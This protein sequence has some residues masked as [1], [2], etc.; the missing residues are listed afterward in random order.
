M[1]VKSVLVFTV[2][3]ALLASCQ[4]ATPAPTVAVA[5]TAPTAVAAPSNTPR[6]IVTS[7]PIPNGP[8]LLRSD[9]SLRK[10]VDRNGGDI[11]LALNPKDGAVFL[12]NPG[13]GVYRVTLTDPGSVDLVAATGEIFT[14]GVTPSGM[15]FGPDGTLYVVGNVVTKQTSNVAI[16]RKGVADAAGKYTWSFLA[17]TEPYPLSGTNFDHL[18]NGIAV[19]PDGKYVYVNAGSRSDHGEVETN[20]GAWPDTREVPLTS[21]IMRIPADSTNLILPNDEAKLKSMGY[22]F[23]DGT[24]NSYDPAFAP[25]G[26]LFAGENGPDADYP[27]EINW[28]REGLHYGFPWRFGNQDLPQATSP[29]Y[30]PT[31]D[32]H[33]HNDFVAVTSGTYKSDPTFPKAPMA[34]TDPIA[35]AGPDGVQFRAD[36]GTAHDVGTEG[37][38]TYSFT[39]HRSPL[40]LVF[41]SDNA[42]M[43]A[44]L[45]GSDNKLSGFIVS[46]GAAG[47]T[48][49]DKGLDL[50]HIVL[51]KSS[52][53]YTMTSE[54]V[55][56]EFK[57]PIDTVLIGN[58]LYVLEFGD[59]AA[60]WELTFNK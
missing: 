41:V 56:R 24:R 36:D 34:F 33:L 29:N 49:T 39:P 15:V 37:G 2:A 40:G 28:L 16:I 14:N 48:L 50:L 20:K 57:N 9:I 25:N 43:P 31:T 47:G 13:E 21:A 59:G 60:I 32:K 5:T 45:Q 58:K 55:A 10:V 51:T 12:L 38:V 44:D 3:M 8:V 54:Q 53:N 17:S 23:A 18:Y 6:V 7:Q 30:D 22:M 52:D 1:K 46:W 4:T 42:N 19:S 26:D 35:N 11:R 27:D